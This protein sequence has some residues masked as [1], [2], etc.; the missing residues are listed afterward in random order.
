MSVNELLAIIVCFAVGYWI[1]SRVMAGGRGKSGPGRPQPHSKSSEDARGAASE[2][3]YERAQEEPSR[4]RANPDEPPGE[5]GNAPA[6]RPWFEVLELPPTASF[7]E[8]R[9][10]Y[11][12]LIG[13]YH[14]DKASQLGKDLRALA[15]E[16]SKEI[17]EAYREGS[18]LRGE[19]V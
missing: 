6:K 3:D 18:R 12:R 15:E 17:N 5:K 14:P 8:I 4:R 11:R 1:V 10:A 7:E 2:T 9:K 19:Q 16:R 13:Q